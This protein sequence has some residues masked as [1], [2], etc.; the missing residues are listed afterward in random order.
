MKKFISILA[1]IFVAITSLCLILTM[2]S[3][4]RFINMDYFNNYY[5]FQ[6][7]T[8]ITMFLWSI[9]QLEL[10]TKEWINSIL[11]MAMGF[12]TIIFMVMEIY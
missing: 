3:T 1:W 5:I 9:K 2:L 4:C 6:V 10:K 7:S 12:C 11:C 8:I